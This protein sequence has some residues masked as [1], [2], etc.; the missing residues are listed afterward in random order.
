VLLENPPILPHSGL[1][2]LRRLL[3][4]ILLASVLVAGC[5]KAVEPAPAAAADAPYPTEA[6]PR[7]QTLKLWLGA[8]ELV[9]EL[10]LNERQ[11]Q[12][13]MMFRT[14]LPE[15]EAMLFVFSRPLRVS[16]WMRNTVLPLS[17]AYIDPSGEIL[18]VHGLKPMD[19]NSVVAASDRI[20][21]V[22]ETSQGW[23]DRHHIGTGT[24]VRTERGSLND[25]FFRRR[26]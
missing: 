17:A 25:T 24:V 10:A 16:F 4:L 21:Y 6:Q 14:N 19:T 8:E 2:K 23:F 7:L 5:R 11:Q 15:N 9:T 3:G 1:M 18:E 22:L 13:G 20:L 12:A 26:Q